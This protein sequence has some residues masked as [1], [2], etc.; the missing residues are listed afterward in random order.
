MKVISLNENKNRHIFF[1]K[2]TFITLRKDYQLY[3]FLLPG[4]IYFIIFH[5]IPMYGVQIAFRDFI[6]IKGIW[7]SPWV[8][9][10][11]FERFISS[12]QFWRLMINT[13]GI[14][15]YQLA[16]GFPIPILLALML[17]QTVNKRFKKVVQTVTYAPHFI[18]IVVLVG[19]IQMFLSPRNG[20][21]NVMLMALGK[22][23]IV[24]LAKAEWYKTIYVLSGI[25]QGAGWGSIIYLAAL[26]G[27]NI[28]LYEAAKVDG[29][30]KFQIIRHIDIPGIM[31]TAVILLILSLGRIMNVGFQKAYLLQND[32]N[33]KSSE[34][35]STYV[36][37]V[38][39]IE[40][41]YSYS[42]AIGLFNTIINIILL[43]SVNRLAKKLTETSLW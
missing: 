41:Q 8:G 20:F 2:K 23:P 10:K 33:L 11:H 31:P 28:E 6:D 5:Y 14:S 24:F 21:V 42:A 27:I 17:N 26:A 15:F 35:I 34:I 1:S 38:G 43:V 36:Y 18:S 4:I 29:A 22:D 37:K 32:M 13:L 40:A 12:Y 25:W 19:M 9:L 3:L 16:A 30:S 39:L 7:G